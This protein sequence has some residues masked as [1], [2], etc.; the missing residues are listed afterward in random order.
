MSM[1]PKPH[2]PSETEAQKAKE[3][4]QRLTK[5]VGHDLK[6]HIEGDPEPLLIPKGVLEVLQEVLVQTSLGR[7]VTAMSLVEKVPAVADAELTTQEAANLLK[8]S[9][10][11]LVK[12]LEQGYIPFRKVGTHRRVALAD[13]LSY[14]A[15]A[16]NEQAE[17][18]LELQKQ[19][20]ELDMGY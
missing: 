12:L 20:Q 8:V 10:P 9:R 14:Q 3:L 19:A 17:A 11:Y 1:L 15:K 13:L 7:S 4:T 18:L 6:V 2:L 16:K 5:Y